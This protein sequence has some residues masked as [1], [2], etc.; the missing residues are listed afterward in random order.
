MINQAKFQLN[1]YGNHTESIFRYPELSIWTNFYEFFVK[2][3][4]KRLM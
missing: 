3:N 4:L 1:E 2:R